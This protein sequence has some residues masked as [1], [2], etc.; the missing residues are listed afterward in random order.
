MRQRAEGAVGRGMA[1]TADDGHPRQGP[2]LFRP[3]D[4][5]DALPHV[6]HRIVDHPEI[7]R[8]LVER[9]DLNPAF[10][11]VD[12]GL[13]P[14]RGGHVVVGHGDGLFGRAHLAVGQAQAFERLRRRDLMHEVTVDIQQAGAV[15][16]LLDDMVVPDF[17]IERTGSGHGSI[18]RGMGDIGSGKVARRRAQAPAQSRARTEQV[19][20]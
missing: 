20:P 18:S 13:T 11:V 12:V 19:A 7:T 9:L 3:D 4:M 17:V 14:R 10:L 1:V 6:R 5:H 8:V 2:A 15:V 16:G